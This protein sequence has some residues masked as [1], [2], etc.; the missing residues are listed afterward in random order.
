MPFLLD[1]L[2]RRRINGIKTIANSFGCWR[3]HLLAFIDFDSCGVG[4]CKDR[5]LHK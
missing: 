4:V 3:T 1:K 2:I 5:N